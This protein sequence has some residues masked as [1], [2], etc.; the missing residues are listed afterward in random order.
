[1]DMKNFHFQVNRLPI[2]QPCPI[3]C[4]WLKSASTN[5][6]VLFAAD[7]VGKTWHDEY[8][9]FEKKKKKIWGYTDLWAIL[10]LAPPRHD[11]MNG[12]GSSPSRRKSQVSTPSEKKKEKSFPISIMGGNL[13]STVTTWQNRQIASANQRKFHTTPLPAFPPPLSY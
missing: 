1:M 4:P 2:T 8:P 10:F 6:H 7:L 3:S 13:F 12:W 11:L 9:V 5:L